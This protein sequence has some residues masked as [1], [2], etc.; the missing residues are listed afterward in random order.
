VDDFVSAITNFISEIDLIGK[1]CDLWHFPGEHR[2]AVATLCQN[3]KAPDMSMVELRV[4]V[5]KDC[6]E[7]LQDYNWILYYCVGCHESRWASRE[8]SR[9]IYPFGNLVYWIRECPECYESEI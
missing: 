2:E 7:A 8:L 4:A 5:C 9:K 1:E 3:F 6:M